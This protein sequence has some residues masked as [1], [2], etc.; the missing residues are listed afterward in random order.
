MLQITNMKTLALVFALILASCNEEDEPK[1]DC[2]PLKSEMELAGQALF[3]VERQNPF[4]YGAT[5][6]SKEVEEYNLQHEKYFDAYTQA[7]TN[8]HQCKHGK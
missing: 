2:T 6:T 4:N 3:S 8:F 1:K 5:P 7:V